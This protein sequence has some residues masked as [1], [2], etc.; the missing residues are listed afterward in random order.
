VTDVSRDHRKWWGIVTFSVVTIWWRIGVGRGVPASKILTAIFVAVTHYVDD[1]VRWDHLP[2]PLGLA[3]L[4][5]LRTRLREKN[6]YSTYPGPHLRAAVVGLGTVSAPAAGPSPTGTGATGLEGTSYLALRTADGTFNDLTKPLMGAAG[7]R[8]GRNVPIRATFPDH[9]NIMNPSPREIS[10]QLLTRETFQPATSLNLLAGSWLQFMIRDWLSHGPGEKKDPWE[11]PLAQGD[12]WPEPSVRVPRTIADPT[13]QTSEGN[14]PPTHIN[15]E[16]HWWDGSQ[17]YGST[18]ATQDLVRS[19]ADGKLL[20]DDERQ[21]PPVQAG[22]EDLPGFWLGLA[23]MHT[24]FT[25]EH[26]AICDQLKMSYPSWSDDELFGRARLINAAVMAKIHTVEWTPAIIGHPTTKFALRANWWGLEMERLNRLVGRLSKSEVISGIPGSQTDQFGIPYSLT[27]EFVAVYKMHPLIP[28]DYTVRR[29]IDDGVLSSYGFRD[30]SQEN[31]LKVIDSTSMTD[32]FYSFG[33]MH[34]GAITLHNYPRALQLFQRPRNSGYTDLAA[35][36]ILRARELGVPRYARFRELLGL[37]VPRSFE[38]LSSNKEWVDQIRAIYDNDLEL[39]D[40]MIGLFAEDKP[41][42]F[43]FS[44]TAFRIFILMA[45]RRLNSDRFFTIEFTPAIYTPVGMQW[46]TDNGMQSVLL[47]HYPDLAP[48]FRGVTNPF[49]P[50]TPAS[51]V[52][53]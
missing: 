14:L 39:V 41:S 29:A 44:D 48:A 25:L 2:M 45:S 22:A 26:N 24:L 42:G 23:M 17:I 47:R 6:L 5:G 28:D 4:I 52:P 13:R 50:W 18:K 33:R 46:I 12:S 37:P 21:I 43:G 40:L 19:G 31:T 8:F 34:P 10:R 3:T 11:I 35:T 49:A 1:T 20:W 16:T 51:G 9:A 27:E 36:D 15:T 32:L 30:L 7:T 38:D 53:H